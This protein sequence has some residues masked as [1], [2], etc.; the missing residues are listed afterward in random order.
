MVI[1]ENK[2]KFFKAEV[3]EPQLLVFISTFFY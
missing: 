1:K 2:E 3:M